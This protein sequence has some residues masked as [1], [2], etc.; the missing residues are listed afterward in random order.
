MKS[1]Y[2]FGAG[3]TLGTLKD[4]D[5][6]PPVAANFGAAI[7]K[8]PEWKTEFPALAHVAEHLGQ[9]LKELG[10]EA[11]WS[12]LDYFAKLN[13]ALPLQKPWTDEART[14]KKALLSVYGEICDRAAD[15]LPDSGNYTLRNIVKNDL[16]E[17]DILISFNYDTLVERL[18][19]RIGRV[20]Q[21]RMVCSSH[22]QGVVWVAKPHG[23]ASWSIDFKQGSLT[24][25][26]PDGGPRLKSLTG[27]DLLN[28]C[29]P[30]MLGAVP[31]K[32]ELIREVQEHCGF[33]AIH[34]VIM[35]QWRSVVAALRDVER[36]IVLGYCFPVE[37][38][39]G[40]FLF[41]EAVRLR[42]KDKPPL[43][44]EFYE[45]PDKAGATS[46][47]IFDALGSKGLKVTYCGS[48]TPP[49]YRR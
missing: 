20:K 21:L 6:P 36:I 11:I 45:L 42:P 44:V 14:I 7:E 35:Q 3:S 33:P 4:F 31:I 28:H 26:E 40:R 17:G 18:A 47:N 10:L 9:P 30:L 19:V 1:A 24:W 41:Q 39:Y 48:V 38:Q 5:Q 25:M 29:E 43:E 27:A 23:S 12:C 8:L 22:I 37:D 49:K 16:C 34:E 13:T 2:I 32:S 46:K 15:A